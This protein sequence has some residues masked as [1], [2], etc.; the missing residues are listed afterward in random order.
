MASLIKCL[1]YLPPV[2]RAVSLVTSETK[3]RMSLQTSTVAL[4]KIKL[5]GGGEGE[6]SSSFRDLMNKKKWSGHPSLAL[7]HV[8]RHTFAHHY[9][10]S[11]A[12]LRN[13]LPAWS[14]RGCKDQR[15]SRI[16]SAGLRLYSLASFCVL[17]MAWCEMLSHKTPKTI[18]LL[19][20]ILT[21]CF[22]QRINIYS[23]K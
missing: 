6:Y 1:W 5:T 18:S 9:K 4:A 15:W 23:K 11:T 21:H 8:T 10:W 12:V 2:T 20:H 7:D 17:L 16:L 13:K 19:R 22:H 14:R 3:Y